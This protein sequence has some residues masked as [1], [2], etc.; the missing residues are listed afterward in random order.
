MQVP[1]SH[2]LP[3]IWPRDLV[4]GIAEAQLAGSSFPCRFPFVWGCFPEVPSRPRAGGRDFHALSCTRCSALRPALG[5]G[6]LSSLC[7]LWIS[8]EGRTPPSPDRSVWFRAKSQ[9]FD[10][11]ICPSCGVMDVWGKDGVSRARE[12]GLPVVRG[13]DSGCECWA[14]HEQLQCSSLPSICGRLVWILILAC[15]SAM[16]RLLCAQAA[17]RGGTADPLVTAAGAHSCSA[18]GCFLWCFLCTPALRFPF[19]TAIRS[20]RPERAA[21]RGTALTDSVCLSLV[22]CPT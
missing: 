21:L 10:L 22:P 12:C 19:P 14:W 6:D 2:S 7:L 15:T 13:W 1:G 20:A 11:Q 3:G 9:W 18:L 8:R 5:C 4:S 16:G 17:S